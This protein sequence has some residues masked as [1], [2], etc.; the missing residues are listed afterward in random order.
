MLAHMGN[1]KGQAAWNH[2]ST[3]STLTCEDRKATQ[4]SFITDTLQDRATTMNTSVYHYHSTP[5]SRYI[6]DIY[7]DIYRDLLEIAQ[8]EGDMP[9][10]RSWHPPWPG[11]SWCRKRPSRSKSRANTRSTPQTQSTV[12]STKIS[13]DYKQIT[14]DYIKLHPNNIKIIPNTIRYNQI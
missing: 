8:L 14:S 4:A 7:R 9:W 12:I 1:S 13:T 10:L 5:I 3:Y 2:T 11:R 6:P